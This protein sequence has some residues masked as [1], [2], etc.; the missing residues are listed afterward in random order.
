MSFSDF[1][2]LSTFICGRFLLTFFPV[3]L[4]S[5]FLASERATFGW[6][7][8]GAGTELFAKASA[9]LPFVDFKAFIGCISPKP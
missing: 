9:L 4:L 1:E 2:L 3:V 7:L 6:P 5:T 8:L